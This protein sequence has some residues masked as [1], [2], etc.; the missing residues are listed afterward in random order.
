MSRVPDFETRTCATARTSFS[1]SRF[2]VPGSTGIFSGVINKVR[3]GFTSCIVKSLRSRRSFISSPLGTPQVYVRSNKFDSRSQEGCG[4]RAARERE[5]ERKRERERE[6]ERECVCVR[7]R[8]RDR[9]CGCV[10]GCVRERKS[11]CVCVC[12]RESV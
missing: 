4:P 12:A 10:G 6:R 2:Q 11:V 9:L 1:D 8:E 7:E 5:R 3:Q